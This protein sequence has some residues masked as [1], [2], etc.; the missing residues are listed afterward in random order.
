MT[1]YALDRSPATVAQLGH[2]RIVA[3]AVKDARNGY[4][5]SAHN[6]HRIGL[7]DAERLCRSLYE[8]PLADALA[9]NKVS[10][11]DPETTA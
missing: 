9:I 11:D 2:A 1:Y 4:A 8:M 5:A 6:R 3:F 10:V 7:A